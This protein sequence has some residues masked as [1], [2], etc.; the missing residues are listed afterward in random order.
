MH[1]RVMVI[2]K[3][4]REHALAYRLSRGAGEK[5]MREVLITPGNDGTAFTQPC[6]KPNLDGFA[7]MIRTVAPGTA[8]S[9]FRA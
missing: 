8:C 4:A 2:G 9:G 1:E 6:M 5:V 7:G 3:G